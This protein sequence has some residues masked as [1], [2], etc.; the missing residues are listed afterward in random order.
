MHSGEPRPEP[1]L[2]GGVAEDAANETREGLLERGAPVTGVAPAW[3]RVLAGIGFVWLIV[4]SLLFESWRKPVLVVLILLAIVVAH[5]LGHFLIARRAGMACSEFFVGFGPRLWSRKRGETEFG[6]KLL[7]LGG[8]V[9][10]LGMTNLEKVDPS[11]ESQTYRQAPFRWRFATI[12]GGVTVNF[13]LAFVCFTALAAG[14]G[15]RAATTTIYSLVS[16]CRTLEHPDRPASET[17]PAKAAGI[18]KG[19]VILEIAGKPVTR[20]KQMT[21]AVEPRLGK[22]TEITV[23]RGTSVLHFDVVPVP[24]EDPSTGGVLRLKDGSVAALVGLQPDVGNFPIAA[25]KAPGWALGEMWS[26]TTQ[27]VGVLGKLATPDGVNRQVKNAAGNTASSEG[28]GSQSSSVGSKT[29]AS[30]PKYDPCAPSGDDLSRPR[31]VI[32]IVQI[33]ACTTSAWD[34]VAIAGSINLALGIINVVPLVPLDGGH[35][36]VAVYEA[37]AS[38]VRRRRVYADYRKLAPVAGLFI[39][40]LLFVFMTSASADIRDLVR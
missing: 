27:T 4:A 10:I 31:S 25:A 6:L 34:Y 39:V 3:V 35:A 15:E 22:Q 26:E 30:K 40:F 12:M 29:S 19:D 11:L 33:G 38:R 13:V 8:Y 2:R 9:R 24:K 17:C 7:P 14:N 16:Q 18:Q 36:V 23:R 1:N 37:I 32:G 21:E 28:S 20:G 5:E